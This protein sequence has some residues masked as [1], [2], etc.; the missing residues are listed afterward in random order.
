[1]KRAQTETRSLGLGSLEVMT[2][3][4]SLKVQLC[5][6]FVGLYHCMRQSQNAKYMQKSYQYIQL[7]NWKKTANFK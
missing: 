7:E 6:S 1:M 4:S 3:F 5:Y 2:I